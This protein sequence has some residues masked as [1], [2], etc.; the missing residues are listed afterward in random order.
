[1]GKENEEI[2]RGERAGGCNS[3]GDC[4]SSMCMFKEALSLIQA[5]ERKSGWVK[6]TNKMKELTQIP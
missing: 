2:K 5:L 3:A 6:K 4:L 1:M